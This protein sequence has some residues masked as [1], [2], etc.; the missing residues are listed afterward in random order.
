MSCEL[1]NSPSSLFCCCPTIISHHTSLVISFVPSFFFVITFFY[2]LGDDFSYFNAWRTVTSFSTPISWT[3]IWRSLV[4]KV[5]LS[6]RV[7]IRHC[8]RVYPFHYVFSEELIYWYLEYARVKEKK[9]KKMV[10]SALYSVILH[11]VY[12]LVIE[13]TLLS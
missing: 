3:L 7:C 2:A 9:M 6:K 1:I 8:L 4:E 11:W 13:A 5:I 12:I 10:I